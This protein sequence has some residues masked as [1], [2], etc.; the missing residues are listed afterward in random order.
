MKKLLLT[1]VIFS[2]LLIIGCQ[3]NSITEPVVKLEK[4][5]NTI[6][7]DTLQLNFIIEDP[8]TG[9]IELRGEVLYTH[10]LF[11]T[12]DRFDNQFLVSVSIEFD[13]ELIDKLGMMH[14]DWNSKG[15][16]K[17]S[18]YVSEEGIYILEKT[19]GITNRVDVVLIVQ[20]LVSTEGVGVPNV[21]L[22]LNK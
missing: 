20:Y 12:N 3:E 5:G 6:T 19:Y 17:D 13:S 16:S 1:I 8:L 11:N 4:A 2:V 22:E 9:S 10:E 15:Q 21:W 18:I 14:P 7:Q